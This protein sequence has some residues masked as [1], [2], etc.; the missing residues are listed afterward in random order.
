[1]SQAAT[2]SSNL[3]ALSQIPQLVKS[4]LH[5]IKKNREMNNTYRELNSLSDS[6]LRDIGIHRSNIRAIAMEQYYDNRGGAQ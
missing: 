6:E 3:T 5:S 2:A 4:L 1:M